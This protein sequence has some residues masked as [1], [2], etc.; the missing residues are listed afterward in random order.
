[1]VIKMKQFMQKHREIILYL[2]FGAITTVVGFVTYLAVFAVA[3]HGLG[4]SMDDKT[5]PAYLAVYMAAQ[6]IQWV[7]AVLTAFYTNRKWVFTDADHSKGSL[8]KQ[9]VLFSG[10]RVAT[11]GL[12]IVATFLF[13]QLF[14][15]W[16]DASNPPAL[17]G[18]ALTAELWAKVIV[19]V[20]V[21]VANYVL[22][23]LIVFKKKKQ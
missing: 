11:L 23:K 1:M 4:I 3:E 5:A 20:L 10:S 13:I 7:V 16:I 15:L 19:S 6:V 8:W 12:D 14:N 17:L 2:L 9:L 18:I 22:S 21:I